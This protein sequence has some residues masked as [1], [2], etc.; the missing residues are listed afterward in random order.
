MISTLPGG[1][2]PNRATEFATQKPLFADGGFGTQLGSFVSNAAMPQI[3]NYGLVAGFTLVIASAVTPQG[4]A[5]ASEYQFGLHAQALHQAEAVKSRVWGSVRT[6]PAAASAVPLRPIWASPEQVD[7]SI[8]GWVVGGT[9]AN[10]GPVPPTTLTLP[11]DPTHIAAQIWKSQPAVVVITPNPAASFFSVPPQFEERPTRAVWQSLRA[12]Q[13]TPV[14]TSFYAAP[15]QADLT[16][17][18]VVVPSA[19]T[20]PAVGLV[21][22]LTR[23]SPQADPSQPAAQVWKSVATPPAIVG[24]TVWPAIVAPPQFDTSVNP[25]QIWTTSTFSA[26]ITPPAIALDDIGAKWPVKVAEYLTKIKDRFYWFRDESELPKDE[27]VRAKPSKVIQKAEVAPVI[28]EKVKAE[29]EV[30]FNAE[31]A[32]R[33]QIEQNNEAIMKLFL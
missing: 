32:K 5:N 25:T 28:A 27:P 29:I 10:Q 22:P 15:Q 26:G 6:P 20:P 8:S 33:K 18:G 1:H 3:A 23:G 24:V 9:R 12:G 31:L 14:I 19:I 17:Q 2:G 16:Q 11:Q 4:Q 21:P 7:L 30:Q 13:L